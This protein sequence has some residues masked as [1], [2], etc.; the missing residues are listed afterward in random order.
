[1]KRYFMSIPEAV[2]L[3]LQAMSMGRDG[4]VHVLDMGEP[5][6][7]LDLAESVIRLSGFTPYVDIDIVETQMRPGEKL[8]EEIL[9]DHE[10]FT[11][12]SHQRLFIAKQE[13]VEYLRLGKAIARLHGVVRKSDWRAALEIAREF[14]PEYAPDS[15]LDLAL[16]KAV[17]RVER[18]DVEMAPIHTNGRAKVALYGTR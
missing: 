15:R 3:V 9:T 10:D 12:T 1:M 13:R 14:V 18:N 7:I 4:E 17:V 11:R 5:I 6:R 16:P 2:S 8:F